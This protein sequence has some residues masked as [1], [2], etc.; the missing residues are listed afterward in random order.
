MNK[1]QENSIKSV[2]QL[3]PD[4]IMIK[5]TGRETLDLPFHSHSSNQII[6]TVAGTLH[7]QIGD[8]GYFVP[9]RHIAWIPGNTPHRLSS[10]NRQIDLQMIF[11][12]T[13]Y[14]NKDSFSVYNTN[15]FIGE[16]LK[17]V[18]RNP[19]LIKKSEYP[20]LFSYY[21]S[22]LGLLP[23][24]GLEYR[25]PLK[26]LIIPEDKRLQDILEYINRNL[27]ED[28]SMESVALRFGMS[29]RS[30]SR[31]FQGAHLRFTE[32]V[33]YQRI[34]RAIELIAD[35]DKTMQEIAYDVGFNTPT[36]FNRVF[37]QILGSSPSQFT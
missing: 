3:A 4:E 26:T 35:K 12:P 19:K 33:N 1:D 6:H 32:Y 9:E 37:K 34:T 16:N 18:A 20:E 17:F 14:F 23:T 31:L 21:I 24:L 27:S 29:V 8:T 25:M 13:A 36:H 22:F 5:E 11:Y 30:V 10:N 28:L 15:T 2:C 7:I